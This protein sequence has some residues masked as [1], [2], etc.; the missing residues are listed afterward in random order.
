MLTVNDVALVRMSFA[1]IAPIQDNA[2]DLFYDRLFKLAPKLRGMFPSDLR[3]QKT[4]LMA[5]LTAAVAGLHEVERLTPA[6]RS[7][8]AR[9]AGY[10]VTVAHYAVVG[11]ALMW[12]LQRALGD[13]FTAEVRSAWAKVYA[14][15]AVTMQSGANEADGI[16]AAV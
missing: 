4:K 5:V 8:G 2:A 16:R 12:T 1:R 11:D 15:V 7:L 13:D 14:L 9:H 6:L 10:G 3:E